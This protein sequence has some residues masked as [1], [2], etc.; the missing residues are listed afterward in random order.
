MGEADATVLASDAGEPIV[1]PGLAQ[2]AKRTTT[3]LGA[4]PARRAPRLPQKSASAPVQ[5]ATEIHLD[6][7]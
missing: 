2:P 4:A 1:G 3:K 7:F 6:D 5:D